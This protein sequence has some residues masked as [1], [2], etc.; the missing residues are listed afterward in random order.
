MKKLILTSTLRDYKPLADVSAPSIKAYA[1]RIGAEFEEL[2]EEKIPHIHP[3]WGVLQIYDAL[4]RY[5]RVIYI[6]PD[7]IV[8]DDCPDLFEVVPREKVGAYP[9]QNADK[10]TK[11]LAQSATMLLG[12][13]ITNPNIYDSGVLVVS[14]QHRDLFARPQDPMFGFSIN[15]Y[16]SAVFASTETDI[17]PLPY[18]YNRLPALDASTG[19]ERFASYIIHYTDYPS[20]EVLV[21]VMRADLAVWLANAG[22]HHYKKNIIVSVFGGL[23][24]HASAEPAIRYLREHLYPT[25]NFRISCFWPRMYEHLGVPVH[26]HNT[27]NPHGITY[28]TF[29]TLPNPDSALSRSV[30]F[31]LTHMVDFHAM[32]MLMRM[33]PLKDR[34]IRLRPNATD[35]ERL[36]TRTQGIDMSNVVLVHAGQSWASKTLPLPWWQEV[37]NLLAKEG[38]TVCLIGKGHSS[39]E[40]DKTGLVPVVCPPSGM[41]LRDT[42]ELGELFALMEAAPVLLTNDSSPV[43]LA[44]AFDNWIVMLATCKHPD[45]VFPYR[46]G[47]TQYKTKALYKRLLADDILGEPVNGETMH[48]DVPVADWPVYLPEPEVVAKEV[49]TLYTQEVQ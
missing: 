36:N 1:N 15:Q 32:T 24:D 46:K 17:V 47:S 37:V 20:P 25:D 5:D 6:A 38:L 27:F 39:V 11:E 3:S 45:L 35:R 21:P 49:A 13:E 2:K 30:S 12:T 9:L 42:L 8:R 7:C 4:E 43:Q 44:G 31:L 29:W 16:I 18:T 48:V 28:R 19:E 41:D 10:K 40:G 26:V 34:E 22:T 33:L 14:K 23:G